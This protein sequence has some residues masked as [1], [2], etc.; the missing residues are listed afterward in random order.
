MDPQRLVF[1]PVPCGILMF[2]M[3]RLLHDLLPAPQ[4]LALFGAFGL[5]YVAYDCMHYT[6]HYGGPVPHVILKHMKKLHQM[7]HYKNHAK[8]YGISTP[9]FD[10]MFGTMDKWGGGY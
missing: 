8:G 3:Y 6:S 10:A 2:G 9:L 1:P 5:G 7:H 4:A